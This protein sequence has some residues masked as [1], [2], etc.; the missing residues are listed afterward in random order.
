MYK[1]QLNS[2]FGASRLSLA[3]IL[4]LP[5]HFT[6]SGQTYST[7]ADGDWNNTTNVWSIDGVTLCSC[8]PSPNINGFDVVISHL[9]N[10]TDDLTIRSGNSISVSDGAE[11]SNFLYT[12]EI[13]DGTLTSFGLVKAKKLIVLTSGTAMLLGLTEID[14]KFIIEGTVTFDSLVI[15][16]NTNIEISNTGILNME[17]G[18]RVN[19]LNGN[20]YNYGLIIFNMSCVELTN[21]SLDNREN[22]VVAG[23]GYVNA[24]NGDIENIG[25]WSPTVHWCASG[26]GTGMSI[27]ED[28]SIGPCGA[29]ILPIE[30]LSFEV[31]N[32]NGI[33]ELYWTT[34]SELNNDYF[35]VERSI[36]GIHFEEVVIIES[37]Q[38]INQS[39]RYH[40]QDIDPYNGMSYYRLKQTDFDG[41]V[42]YFDLQSVMCKSSIIDVTIYP[43]PSN[44]CEIFIKGKSINE[45]RINVLI[46]NHLSEIVYS[47]QINDQVKGKDIIVD[48]QNKLPSGIYVITGNSSDSEIFRKKL[49][50]N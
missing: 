8:S 41:E 42:Q 20:I 44:G 23:T 37:A 38:T 47:K 10:M 36:D 43:N 34:M 1:T 33:V 28:C 17:H 4:L 40:A 31:I 18:T 21:G 35:T 30:L 22:S 39:L 25:S 27:P 12:I 13:E 49:V 5:L 15:A 16:L 26:V 9:V 2:V 3:F 50:M 48:L 32:I 6:C 11:I 14:L 46:Y 45:E 24:M 7:L 29:I 19:V